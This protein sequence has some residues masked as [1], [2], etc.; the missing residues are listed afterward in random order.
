[1]KLNCTLRLAS[2]FISMACASPVTANSP[3]AFLGPEIFS[4]QPL[5]S[6]TG[7]TSLVTAHDGSVLVFR[8]AQNDQLYRSSDGA[9]TWDAPAF[10]GSSAAV[11]NAVVDETNGDII[12]LAPSQSIRYLSTNNGLTWTQQ[13][14]TVSLDLLGF[15]GRHVS[16]V[17]SGI[18]MM[19]GEFSGRLIMPI[20]VLGPQGADTRQWRALHYASAI[21]S[22]D[23]GATWQPGRPFPVMG[24]AEGAIAQL[25]DG[26]LLY[27]AREQ[28]SL[29]GTYFA[30]SPVNSGG[31]HWLYRTRFSELPDGPRGSPFGNV[32]GLIR[33]PIPG[34][35]ILLYSNVD[36]NGGELPAQ[37]GG[38]STSGRERL[39]VWASLDG[40]QTWPI[41]RLVFEGPAGASLMATGR[42]GTASQGMIYLLFEGGAS[43]W[44]SGVQ[45]ASFNLSWLLDGRDIYDYLLRQDSIHW[46]GQSDRWGGGPSASV[47]WSSAPYTSQAFPTYT[48]LEGNGVSTGESHHFVYDR[49]RLIGDN[50]A[51]RMNRN[52]VEI[53]S[54]LLRGTGSQGMRFTN[55]D[56]NGDGLRLSGDIVVIGGLHSFDLPL[57]GR[58]LTLTL[59]SCWDISE[60]STLRFSHRLSGPFSIRKLGQGGLHL[61][62][63][64]FHT[65][66]TILEEGTL[67]AGSIPAFLPGNLM[68]LKQ[69]RLQF[70]SDSALIV[71]GVVTFEFDF[72]LERVTG[73][74]AATPPG[75]YPLIVGQVDKEKVLNIGPSQA[76]AIA[77]DKQA[78]FED[79]AD[80]NIIVE[81]NN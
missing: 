18:T 30:G 58:T 52:D 16:T 39:S 45:L 59:D 6:G 76:I 15:S 79:S 9:V 78:Y 75:R 50:A 55:L 46:T 81:A 20:R 5:W 2:I 74:T 70:N 42:Q 11:G 49:D 12:V 25:S 3:R 68:I 17:H 65:G 23:R 62:G 10:I 47:A 71:G 26:S 14:A 37:V 57:D 56:P 1:M 73:L 29:G 64:Q 4:L 48:L 60:D 36:S 13:P 38:T 31:A 61:S 19:H 69:S 32:G 43:G 77:P 24:T 35:D 67:G 63:E 72:G 28:I 51:L 53:K 80:L 40:G 27:S 22:D 54:I 44:N 34:T 66:S 41:K 33:L 8:G 7:A 21:F